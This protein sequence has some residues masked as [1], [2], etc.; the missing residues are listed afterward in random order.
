M[1]GTDRPKGRGLIRSLN[2]KGTSFDKS[3]PVARRGG[4]FKDP[5]ICERCGAVYERKS[6]HRAGRITTDKL[7]GAAWVICPACAEAKSG[8]AYGKVLVSGAFAREHLDQIRRRIGN[9]DSRARANQPE[10]RILSA[11][12]DGKTLEILTTSQKLAHRIARELE[13][14]FGGRAK[15][16]WSD[17]DGSLFATW[18]REA[19]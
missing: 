16:N 15:Y 2:R 12:W 8:I 14:V 1:K 3:P 19:G 5:S 17:E 6:W 9:V 4:S 7:S 10:R 13:K 11:D 18:K